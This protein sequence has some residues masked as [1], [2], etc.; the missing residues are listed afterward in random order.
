MEEKLLLEIWNLIEEIRAKRPLVHNFSNVITVNDCANI[1]LAL[2]AKPT[3]AHHEREVYEITKNSDSLV[4]NLGATEYYPAILESVKAAKDHK[5]PLVLDPVAVSASSFRRDFAQ[6]LIEG[7][8]VSVL[9]GNISEI[10][11][12][13]YEKNTARGVDADFGLIEKS[14]SLYKEIVA[15]AKEKSLQVIVSGREDLVTDGSEAYLIKNSSSYMSRLTGTGC[16]SSAL[17]G[18]FFAID[19]G[20]LS[21]LGLCLL[22]SIAGEGAEKKA[23]EN[24]HGIGSFKGYLLDQVFLMEKDEFLNM[25]NIEKIY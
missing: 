18:S 8:G 9:R 17:L 4:I 23:R 3:M 14:P 6:D 21:G 2:G 15:F 25:A 1:L 12:L 11:A 22:M 13:I 10:L 19:Q 24:K 16:M 5:I 7:G 20:I